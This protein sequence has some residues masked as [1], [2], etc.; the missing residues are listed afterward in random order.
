MAAWLRVLPRGIRRS[1]RLPRQRRF[2]ASKL[3]RSV[4]LSDEGAYG[5]SDGYQPPVVVVRRCLVV[6]GLTKNDLKGMPPCCSNLARFLLTIPSTAVLP[7][8]KRILRDR[9]VEQP[10]I[11]VARSH[12]C[13]ESLSQWPKDMS[14]PLSANGFPEMAF[15]YAA[16]PSGRPYHLDPAAKLSMGCRHDGRLACR[17]AD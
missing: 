5:L 9:V 1:R 11:F 10:D 15:Q 7:E 3:V 17:L 12:R 16:V 8:A 6:I 13:G 4:L 14:R 2:A